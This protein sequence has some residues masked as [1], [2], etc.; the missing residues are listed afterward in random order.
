MPVSD[1][2]GQA[3]FVELGKKGI[4]RCIQCR[5][6]A[7]GSIDRAATSTGEAGDKT[8]EILEPADHV[9]HDDVLRV[10]GKL[11]PASASAKRFHETFGLQALRNLGEMVARY[12]VA[13]RDFLHRQRVARG[14]ESHE[15]PEGIIAVKAEL[16]KICISY[17]EFFAIG[18]NLH[19]RY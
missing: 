13:A 11:H 5:L 7:A 16:H 17:I 3:V 12:T 4:E 14:G 9:A 2:F 10:A 8:V 18:F 6:Q 15:S 19:L 1:Q